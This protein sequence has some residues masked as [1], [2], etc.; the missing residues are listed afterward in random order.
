MDV[1]ARRVGGRHPRVWPTPEYSTR[2]ISARDVRRSLSAITNDLGRQRFPVT[3]FAELHDCW[4]TKRD[5][6][7]P[8][9]LQDIHGQ[10]GETGKRPGS[11]TPLFVST[12]GVSG[13]AR[14]A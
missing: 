6:R 10:S 5:C 13:S 12:S 9:T 3:S 2:M 8:Q 7:N 11:L 14:D 1:G 4:E